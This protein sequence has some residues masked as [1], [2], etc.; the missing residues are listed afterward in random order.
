[1]FS[2]VS[3]VESG[4]VAVVPSDWIISEGDKNFAYWPPDTMKEDQKD[5][6]LRKRIKPESSWP[7]YEVQVRQTAGDNFYILYR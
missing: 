2:V 1:M 6:A 4:D 5:R 3:F 7:M